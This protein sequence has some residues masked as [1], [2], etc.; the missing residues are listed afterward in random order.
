[1]SHTP[2]AARSPDSGKLDNFLQALSDE[3]PVPG[4]T[5]YCRADSNCAGPDG[6]PEGRLGSAA[7]VDHHTC[8]EDPLN[9]TK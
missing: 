3:P 4:Y 8:E 9:S 1:M 5:A 2:Q 6:S 7:A